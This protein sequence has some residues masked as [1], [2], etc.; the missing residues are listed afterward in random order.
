M[1]MLT[2]NVRGLGKSVKRRAVKKLILNT[3]PLAILLQETKLQQVDDFIVRSLWGTSNISW[4]FS[5]SLGASGGLITLWDENFFRLESKFIAQRY[6][7]LVGTLI[8]LNLKCILGNIYAPNDDNERL[9]LWDELITISDSQT[10]SWIL[11]GDFNV[12]RSQ[13]EKIGLRYNLAAMEQFSRFIEDLGLIDIQL[14]NGKFT[15]CSNCD[16]PTFCRLDRFLISAELVSKFS[17][18]VQKVLPRSLS[19]HN[20]VTISEEEIDW[21]P[22]PFKFFNYWLEIEG[23]QNLVS[24]VWSS[25]IPNNQQNAS[26]WCRLRSIKP[27]IKKWQKQFCNM[28]Q[29][30]IK[31]LELEIDKMELDLQHN[32]DDQVLLRNIME[33]KSDLWTACKIEEKSWQ[34]KSRLMWLQEGDRNTK[35]FQLMATNRRRKNQITTLSIH[36][37]SISNPVQIKE[38]IASHFEDQYKQALTLKLVD[39]DCCFKILSNSSATNLLECA[40]WFCCLSSPLLLFGPVLIELT[41]CLWRCNCTIIDRPV[42]LVAF[43][44]LRAPPRGLSFLLPGGVSTLV[45]LVLRILSCYGFF[46]FSSLAVL[47]SVAVVGPALASAAVPDLKEKMPRAKGRKGIGYGGRDRG[48]ERNRKCRELS[49]SLLLS[50]Q[51]RTLALFC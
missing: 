30:G 48:E 44:I 33:K 37:R 14:Q 19:D 50:R 38:F 1:K 34:Q 24:S 23:F 12:V 20:P 42:V 51:Y 21:G 32:S 10:S 6:I 49:G 31:R 27:A 17:G 40:D 47:S 2:W 41:L 26:L 13:E 16:Q 25:F 29:N 35:F 43:S 18:L 15:W 4:E 45:A 36:G 28:D 39:L 11:G 5:G 3:K 46:G 9:L 8:P 22:K 7:L